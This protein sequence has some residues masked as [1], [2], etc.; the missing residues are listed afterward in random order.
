MIPPRRKPR[1]S[2][3]D[4]AYEDP[5]GRCHRRRN[6]HDLRV[7][8][9]GTTTGAAIIIAVFNFRQAIASEHAAGRRAGRSAQWLENLPRWPRHQTAR[10][11]RLPERA[12]HLRV[13]AGGLSSPFVR[14]FA[15]GVVKRPDPLPY[16][17]IPGRA[18]WR[19]L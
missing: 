11:G 19:E 17:V 4:F 13:F 5:I 12:V 18:S 15:F 9:I 14:K 6:S 2:E 10:Q 8:A 3:G 1:R 7:C 16:L